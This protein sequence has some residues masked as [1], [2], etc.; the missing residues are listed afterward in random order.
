FKIVIIIRR[1]TLITSIDIIGRLLLVPLTSCCCLLN[2]RRLAHCSCRLDK[3]SAGG[4]TLTI[5]RCATEQADRE[6]VHF[7]RRVLRLLLAD[8]VFKLLCREVQYS[9]RC[10][11][12]RADL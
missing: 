2:G 5:E 3:S 8:G 11:K 7:Q 1:A 12:S 10:N 6:F 4:A 9:A